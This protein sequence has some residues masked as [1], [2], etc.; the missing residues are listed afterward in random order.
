MKIL[1]SIICHSSTNF[2][3]TGKKLREDAK[4]CQKFRPNF[5]K[6]QNFTRTATFDVGTVAGIGEM[7]GAEIGV[8]AEVGIE[9]GLCVEL[10]QG[11]KRGD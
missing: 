7:T 1:K 8:R 11:L 10:V 2:L 6:V 9:A 5:V 4:Y 3:A